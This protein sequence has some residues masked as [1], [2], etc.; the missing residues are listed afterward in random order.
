MPEPST[1][2]GM[3][4]AL[5]RGVRPPR[6]LLMPIVFSLGSRVESLAMPQFLSN[7]TRITSA[8]RQIRSVLKVDGVTC[9]FDPLLEAVALGYKVAWSPDGPTLP[10][11]QISGSLRRNLRSPESAPQQGRVPV[12]CDVIRRLKVMLQ[13]EPALMVAMNGPSVLAAQLLARS[14]ADLTSLP[15]DD[16]EFATEVAA[17]LVKAFVEAGADVVLFEE[18]FMGEPSAESCKRWG[19]LLEPISNVIR[20]YEAL[21]VLL[22][23]DAA[24]LTTAFPA[25]MDCTSSW[26]LCPALD[27]IEPAFWNLANSGSATMGMALPPSFF[28]GSQPTTLSTICGSLA[29]FRPVLLT[30]SADISPGADP[31]QVAATLECLRRSAAG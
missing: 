3:I 8:L 19:S 2:R 14:A 28:E 30:S 6:P 18:Q 12:A 24:R 9:Y 26:V 11:P 4:R 5:L 25:I 21:P 13:D 22:L 20:F 1:P 15:A 29:E 23:K 10:Q 17:C 31:K 16:V 7:A 27:E